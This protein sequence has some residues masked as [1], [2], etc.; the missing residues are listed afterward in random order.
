MSVYRFSCRYGNGQYPLC[1]PARHSIKWGRGGKRTD[2]RAPLSVIN[3][4]LVTKHRNTVKNELKQGAQRRV[5]L[6]ARWACRW[7]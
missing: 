5:D 3:G 1:Q 4:I 2:M 7:C 6:T